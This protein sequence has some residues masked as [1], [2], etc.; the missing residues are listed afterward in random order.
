MKKKPK[1]KKIKIKSSPMF[2]TLTSMSMLIR[3]EI[4]KGN[5]ILSS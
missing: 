2:T 1:E 5:R 4:G 3:I